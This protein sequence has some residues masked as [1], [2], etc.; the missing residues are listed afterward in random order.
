M[1]LD[2]EGLADLVDDSLLEALG[3]DITAVCDHIA[4]DPAVLRHWVTQ[5]RLTIV[6]LVARRHLCRSL[7]PCLGQLPSDIATVVVRVMA[8]G[9]GK[10]KGA[11][12]GLGSRTMMM[13]LALIVAVVLLVLVHYGWPSAQR[14]EVLL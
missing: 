12:T 3:T 10:E 1:K 2:A 6:P 4:E 14:G 5:R 9:T 7:V 8:G 13:Q 11:Q